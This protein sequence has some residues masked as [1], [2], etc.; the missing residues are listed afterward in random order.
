[1]TNEENLKLKTGRVLA[2]ELA[3]ISGYE[4]NPEEV[5]FWENWLKKEADKDGE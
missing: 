5:D 3:A 1:M 4:G 2:R